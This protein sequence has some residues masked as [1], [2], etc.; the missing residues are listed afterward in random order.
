MKSNIAMLIIDMQNCFIEELDNP[1][2]VSRT[3]AVINYVAEM[4]RAAK[5]PVIFIKDVE[6]ADQLSEEEL[7]FIPELTRDEKDLVVEKTFSNAFWQTDLKERLDGLGVSFLI[8]AG[9]AAEH[10]VLFTY[11][12]AGENGYRAVM[13]QDG[14]L[15]GDPDNVSNAM[16]NRNF[17]SWPA[18]EEL[19]NE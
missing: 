8:L 4:V 1:G 13:L 19:L 7:D 2:V 11:N 10:C 17:V 5:Q 3:S 16:A 15:S 6:E 18:V 12:G 9:Q 14:I